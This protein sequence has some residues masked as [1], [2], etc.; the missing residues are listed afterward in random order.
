[1]QTEK[2][3]IKLL[4]QSPDKKSQSNIVIPELS[5]MVNLEAIPEVKI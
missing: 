4:T 5:S 1:M 3:L 2:W